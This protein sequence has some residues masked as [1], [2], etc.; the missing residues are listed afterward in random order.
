MDSREEAGVGADREDL[1][2]A[3]VPAGASEEEELAAV[4]RPGGRLSTAHALVVEVGT[5]VPEQF[6]A[7]SIRPDRRERLLG[8]VAEA[9]CGRVGESG[10]VGRPG[11]RP[12]L[13]P[14]WRGD[15]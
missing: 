15:G 10:G 8:V 11:D 3:A 12:P 9:K 6:A 14:R 7:G 5:A 1:E 4:R 2:R 13:S